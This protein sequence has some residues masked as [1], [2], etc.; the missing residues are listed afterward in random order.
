M[1]PMC[2]HTCADMRAYDKSE[3]GERFPQNPEA[4]DQKTYPIVLASTTEHARR[5]EERTHEGRRGDV[6]ATSLVGVVGEWRGPQ[7]AVEDHS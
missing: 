1:Q 7:R 4:K 6:R 3:A 2:I 5:L